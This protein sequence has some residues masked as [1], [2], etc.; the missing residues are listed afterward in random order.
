MRKKPFAIAFSDIHFNKWKSH[1]KDGKRIFQSIKALGEIA[2]QCIF[3]GSKEKPLPLLFSGDL[4]HHPFKVDNDLFNQV[5]SALESRVFSR[6]IKTYA[7][8]GNHD[9]CERNT[10]THASPTWLN[11]FAE[12]KKGQFNLVDFGY[13]DHNNYRIFGIPYLKDNNGFAEALQKM[14]QWLDCKVFNILLIHT[15]LPGAVDC[16]N[17]TIESVDGLPLNLKKA[18]KKFNLVLNGHI[19]KPQV[20]IEG[21]LITIGSPI[22]QVKSDEGEKMGYWIIYSDC[23]YEF[24]PLKG[25][26]RFI[27]LDEDQDEPDDK[28][29]Y[30]KTPKLFVEEKSNTPIM[31][32]SDRVGIAKSFCKTKGATEVQTK[33]LIEILNQTYELTTF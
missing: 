9:Q 5:S 31:K 27:T 13:A 2:D 1:N 8:S 24:K 29:Y 33:L 23:S 19:H 10:F 22:H 12:L 21:K 15:D 26:P 18:F 28:N 17:R 25:Y 14:E 3:L 7:I 6:G 16:S 11:G 20:N 32:S 4:M 30:I